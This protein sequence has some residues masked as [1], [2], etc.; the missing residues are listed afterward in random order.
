MSDLSTLSVRSLVDLGTLYYSEI[1]E[2]LDN[3]M[4][5][6]KATEPD[7]VK[8]FTAEIMPRLRDGDDPNWRYQSNK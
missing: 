3:E 8:R 5:R 1:K 6:R 4:A 7:F 2:V